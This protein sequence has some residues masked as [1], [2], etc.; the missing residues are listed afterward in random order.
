VV[1]R[2][3]ENTRITVPNLQG[4][5]FTEA[6]A[7]LG[8]LK[9][10]FSFIMENQGLAGQ[11]EEKPGTVILQNPLGGTE[12][13]SDETIIVTVSAPVVAAG[14]VAGLF[15]YNLPRNPYP[16]PLTVEA[17]LPNGTRQGLVSTNHS[18]G[19]F[20][21]PYKLPAGSVIILSMVEREIYR[22]TVK[23]P[24]E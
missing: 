5:A 19:E 12:L 7:R 17:E 13:G 14:E 23:A 15:K 20:S 8:Q 22:Q 9:I 1:S 11:G 4:M 18:G 24:V 3:Q 16:L 10:G 6:L 2:G 21:I